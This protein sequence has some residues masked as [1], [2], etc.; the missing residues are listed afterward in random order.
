M[1]RNCLATGLGDS[2]DPIAGSMVR[3]RKGKG[4]EGEEGIED[5]YPNF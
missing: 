4:G 2:L 1:H 3:P 5:R